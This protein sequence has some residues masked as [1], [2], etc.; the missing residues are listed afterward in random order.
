MTT[1]FNLRRTEGGP[2]EQH[3]VVA[4]D[5]KDKEAVAKT[6]PNAQGR[7]RECYDV[8]REDL[9]LVA[10]RTAKGKQKSEYSLPSHPTESQMIRLREFLAICQHIHER[11][12][13]YGGRHIG[14]GEA[15]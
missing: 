10:T 15:A 13:Q 7:W 5:G 11:G 3:W 2:S 4:P 1:W 6:E 14:K 12:G 8:A 9:M